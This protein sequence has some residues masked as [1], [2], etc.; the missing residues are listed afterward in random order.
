MSYITTT[1]T[2]VAQLTRRGKEILAENSSAFKVT[3]F[4]FSDDE[5]NYNYFD[6]TEIDAAN[7]ELSNWPVL[8]GCTNSEFNAG[9]RYTIFSSNEQ[10]NSIARLDTDIGLIRGN[11]DLVKVPLLATGTFNAWPT[12]GAFPFIPGKQEMRP[13]RDSAT[14][15]IN[16]DESSANQQFT[17]LVKTLYGNDPYY[18]ASLADPANQTVYLSTGTFRMIRQSMPDTD[19]TET[20]Q[21][22]SQATI[23]FRLVGDFQ[24]LNFNE[25][26]QARA[27]QA[28]GTAA[29]P[30]TIPSPQMVAPDGQ[31]NT[32][33]ASTTIKISGGNT[34]KGFSVLVLVYSPSFAQWLMGKNITQLG[35]T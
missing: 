9:Q 24:A 17:F 16:Y 7:P 19:P 25:I 35:R 6:G 31:M 32:P 33:I 18:Y 21:E 4:A 27:M 26:Q 15:L 3:S 14:L 11:A 30:T 20:F 23:T 1:G 5:V 34:G 12:F 13:S 29:A 22:Q 8:E 10:L 28:A 2:V